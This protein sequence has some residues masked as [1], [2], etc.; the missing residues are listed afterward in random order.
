VRQ[1]AEQGQDTVPM[2]CR[3][4][5]SLS[6]PLARKSE[7]H[8]MSYATQDFIESLDRAR[9][10]REDVEA[11]LAAWGHG[12]GQGE[13]TGHGWSGVDNGATDWAGG[14]LFR[15]RDGRVG[16][17]TGWCDYTGWGC[18]DGAKVR[19]FADAPDLLSLTDADGG[20]VP[21]DAWDISPADLNRWVS[22]AVTHG[23]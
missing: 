6:A 22:G 5:E 17:L 8:A 13:D 7:E 14:F 12:T 11:V 3:E 10:A 21:P 9:V 19:W 20:P 4:T 18:Q 2:V 23:A 16:Y 15:L 1:A